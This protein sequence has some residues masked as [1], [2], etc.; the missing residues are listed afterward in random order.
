MFEISIIPDMEVVKVVSVLAVVGMI[1]L[2]LAIRYRKIYQRTFLLFW[3]CT[4]SVFGVFLLLL[5]VSYHLY[6]YCNYLVGNYQIL[7]G[8][9]NV[10]YEQPKNGH[11]P[12]D[13]LEI[14]GENLTLDFYDVSPGYNITI[15]NGG[16]LINGRQVK[17]YVYDGIILR[18]DTIKS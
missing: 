8:A 11:A 6:I 13:L 14:N 3:G 15:S 12:G 10:L 7:E 16:L 1:S 4:T 17:L 2:F 5:H 18:I 9:V